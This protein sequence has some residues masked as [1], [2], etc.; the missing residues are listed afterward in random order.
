MGQIYGVRGRSA[1]ARIP[2]ERGRSQDGWS[3]V[4]VGQICG[5]RGRSA[6]ARIPGGRGRSQ[7]E[8]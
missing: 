6:N 8:F 7:V 2:G 3:G 4:L 5:V 1:N